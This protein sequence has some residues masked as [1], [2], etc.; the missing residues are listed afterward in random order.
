VPDFPGLDQ[1]RGSPLLTVPF[2][3]ARWWTSRWQ[4]TLSGDAMQEG[5]LI[6]RCGHNLSGGVD[7]PS[8]HGRRH[9][10]FPFS[11]ARSSF[12]H[13]EAGIKGADDS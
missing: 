4:G 5:Q 12:R 9:N 10:S 1:E 8:F 2:D 7:E 3:H 13:Y 6:G 11:S